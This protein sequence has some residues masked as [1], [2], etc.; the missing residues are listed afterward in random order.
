MPA[1]V[2]LTFDDGLRCHFDSALPI[3][4]AYGFK[5]TFF[6]VANTDSVLKDGLK[7]PRWKKTRWSREDIHLFNG[8]IRNGHEIGSH[9][10]HHRQPFLDKN[11][12]FEAEFSKK[13]IEDRLGLEISS[14]C[15]PFCHYSEA[16]RDA[17]I[18]AGYKQARWGA[19]ESYYTMEDNIDLFKIDCRLI[20]KFGYERVRNNFIGMYGSEDVVGWVRESCWHVLMFHGIGKAK[21]GWWPIPLAEFEREMAE[22][23]K[24]RDAGAVEVATFKDAVETI[25]HLQEHKGLLPTA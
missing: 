16:I 21:D 1:I 17:V 6:L 3:L 7:H 9:S 12:A 8:M 4:D 20:S 18:Q 10:V 25:N 19:N 2:S 22:L 15:Y 14:Y 23:A 5:A 24:L 13:W 11:P